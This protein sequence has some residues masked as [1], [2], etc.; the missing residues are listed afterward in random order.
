VS[1]ITKAM[2]AS[3]PGLL[4]EFIFNLNG[5]E[6]AAN[7]KQSPLLDN[8]IIDWTRHTSHPKGS[9]M[10]PLVNDFRTRVGLTFCYCQCRAEIDNVTGLTAIVIV[11]EFV[12]FFLD[13]GFSV[14]LDR[15]F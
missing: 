10:H 12:N 1:G 2:T 11:I 14:P 15:L 4:T 6:D 9:Q 3:V 5:T 13:H 7:E 8:W